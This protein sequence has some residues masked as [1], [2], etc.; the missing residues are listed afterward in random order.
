MHQATLW[1][2]VRNRCQL[3][4]TQG[5]PNECKAAHGNTKPEE[6][7]GI[8]TN[9]LKAIDSLNGTAPGNS[10]G[11]CQQQ[12]QARKETTVNDNT[13]RGCENTVS[14]SPWREVLNEKIWFFFFPLAI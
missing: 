4:M 5:C 13:V 6:T 12:P 9:H 7:L 1:I 3:T 14:E 2:I 10:R 8:K 11:W